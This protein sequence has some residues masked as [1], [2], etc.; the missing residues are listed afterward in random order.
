MEK[1]NQTQ[2]D[3]LGMI[4]GGYKSGQMSIDEVYSILIDMGLMRGDV[5]VLSS[6]N[7]GLMKKAGPKSTLILR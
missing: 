1:L 6:F 7:T 2:K 5:L 3:L 4:L